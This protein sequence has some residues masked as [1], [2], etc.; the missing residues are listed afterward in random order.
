VTFA[1][2]PVAVELVGRA[3]LDAWNDVLARSGLPVAGLESG[4]P[5]RARMAFAAP[6]PATARSDGD[7]VDVWLLERLPAWRVREALADRLPAGHHWVAVEDI[8]L[9]APALPGRVIA[10]DW[11]LDLAEGING[12]ERLGG[13]ARTLLASSELPRVRVKG[14]TEKRYDLRPLVD[15]LDVDRSTGASGGAVL[16]LRTRIH[17]ELG[18]G[19]PEEVVA[20]LGELVGED[21]TVVDAVRERLILADDAPAPASAAE[22]GSGPRFRSST[23]P[24]RR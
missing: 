15:Q 21:L 13:A 9:G 2:D 7:L 5:G 4:G 12:P 10:A 16:R 6:L 8:W 23:R 19:R 14:T 18:A 24:P 3:A 17:P 22:A 1:R 11:R 20:A